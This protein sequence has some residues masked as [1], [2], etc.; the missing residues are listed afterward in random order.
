MRKLLFIS[1]LFMAASCSRKLVPQ[2]PQVIIKDSVVVRTETRYHSDTIHLPGDTL[3]IITQVPCPDAVFDKTIKKGRTTLS[4]NMFKGVLTI[5]CHEDSLQ[6]VIDSLMEV[7]HFQEDWHN[8]ET[9]V[10]QT[11]TVTKPKVP[12][13]CW[14]LMGLNVLYIGIRVLIW[15]YSMPFK[16]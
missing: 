15:K 9:I 2:A 16:L 4:A 11:V 6:A 5:N 3:Q 8:K 10:T 7:T 13:W 12:K 1:L 14:W